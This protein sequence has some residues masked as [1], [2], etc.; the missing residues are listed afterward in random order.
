MR[1]EH[2]GQDVGRAAI[3]PQSPVVA[4]EPFHCQITYT[5]GG[6]PLGA[7]GTIRVTIP[8]G[9]T[10]PQMAYP[11]AVG[12]VTAATSAES[13]ALAL[14]LQDPQ[15][16]GNEGVWG[17]HVY[18]VVAEGQLNAGDSITV[19][20]GQG[21]RQ[22]L[23]GE[24]AYAR[25]FE[26]EAEF[27]V[28]VDPDGKRSAPAGGFWLLDG[29]QP[30]MEVVGGDA[31]WLAVTLPAT[32]EPGDPLRARVTARDCLA[33]TVP[34]Y[35]GEVTLSLPDGTERVCSASPGAGVGL[36]AQLG[37]ADRSGVI[38]VQASDWEGRLRGRSNPCRVGSGS[39]MFWGDIHTMTVI[40]AGLSRPAPTLAY[41][42]DRAHLDFC[43]L[44]D[45]DHADSYFSDQEWEETRAAVRQYHD[46]GRFA[47]LLGS[48]Y[49]ERQVAGDKNIYYRDD[50]APLL[51]WSDLEGEQPQALWEAL[52]G[53]R[54][55]TVPHHTVSGSHLAR[56]WDHHDPEY[57][58][59]VEVYSIWGSSE[60]E[61]GSRPNY[62]LNNWDNSVQNGLARGY[63]LGLIASADSHDGLP[64]NASWMRV[65]RG[66]RGGLVAVY[67]RELTREAIFDALWERR[68]Y[69]TSGARIL[70]QF[71]LNQAQMGQE[72]CSE[73]DRQQ[74]HLRVEVAG[75]APIAEVV[76][77]RNGDEVWTCPG[78][79]WEACREWVDAEAFDR[80]ALP[81]FDGQPFVYYYVRVAQEDGE[82]AWSSPIWVSVP[83]Q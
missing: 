57:Q 29:A 55:L 45:G 72:V 80:I 7:G 59:L 48:E 77:V 33:N 50:Q 28:A 20:Y 35:E 34:G 76:V 42:R 68:C 39:R 25:Y 24:G 56:P 83:A 54:A 82:L 44:T 22:G 62:W 52:S 3:S 63:R 19:A 73:G 58:R 37:Q 64:G 41:A 75:T 5:C 74:R 2:V 17:C 13:V 81:G 14:H 12:L 78:N 27:T 26:G 66:Y 15:G 4:G 6:Q 1:R 53:R 70:L 65:R 43:A 79:G 67:A 16:G 31:A 60:A 47:T 49:H 23:F 21:S 18:A 9:F 32:A 8:Y 40:S 30:T 10:P 71:G 51:R 38:R 36:E 69:G 11:Q 46:P 61:G